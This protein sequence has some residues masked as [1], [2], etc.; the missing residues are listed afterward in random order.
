MD[1]EDFSVYLNKLFSINP[2]TVNEV[3]YF[4]KTAG[5][6]RQCLE[7]SIWQQNLDNPGS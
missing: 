5:E 3:W 6:F 2:L 4:E 1:S 7:Q